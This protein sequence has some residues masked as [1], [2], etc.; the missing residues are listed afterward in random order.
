M[1]QTVLDWANPKINAMQTEKDF[2]ISPLTG[3]NTLAEEK[4]DRSKGQK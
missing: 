2:N 3:A 4:N 1:R